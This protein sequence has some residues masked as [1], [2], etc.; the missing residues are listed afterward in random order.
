LG[1]L[2]TY[3]GVTDNNPPWGILLIYSLHS[4]W[5]CVLDTTLCDIVCQWLAIGRW[6]SLGTPI[7]S[8]YKTDRHD[9][10]EILLKVVLNTITH[11]HP[12]FPLPTN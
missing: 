2:I 9:I 8:T 10:T 4:S 1:D 6:F 11:P 7:S 12:L 5:R 3:L